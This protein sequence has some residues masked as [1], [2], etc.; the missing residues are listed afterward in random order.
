MSACVSAVDA[1]IIVV[2]LYNSMCHSPSFFFK[3]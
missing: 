3:R 1:V 2:V